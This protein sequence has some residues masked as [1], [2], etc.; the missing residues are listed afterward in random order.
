MAYPFCCTIFSFKQCFPSLN[1]KLTDSLL[2]AMITG[3]LTLLQA[4]MSVHSYPH[5]THGPVIPQCPTS[6]PL[7]LP[8]SLFYKQA[9]L[10]YQL[11]YINSLYIVTALKLDTYTLGETN[12]ICQVHYIFFY[13]KDIHV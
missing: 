10:F 9:L 2:L 7:I 4:V 5:C 11:V 6:D 13:M 8:L 3:L 1:V 12:T